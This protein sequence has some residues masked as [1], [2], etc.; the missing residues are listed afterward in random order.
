[1]QPD[2][3]SITPVSIAITAAAFNIFLLALIGL[4]FCG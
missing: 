2:D 1:M 4:P 3:P